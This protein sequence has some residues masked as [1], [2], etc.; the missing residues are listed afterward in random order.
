MIASRYRIDAEIAEGVW[1]KPLS[2]LL[3]LMRVAMAARGSKK[4]RKLNVFH[5]K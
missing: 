4:G 1:Q 2:D 5:S 3:I